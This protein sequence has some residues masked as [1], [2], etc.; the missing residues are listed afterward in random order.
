MNKMLHKSLFIGITALGLFA[1]AGVA[2]SQTVSAKSKAVKVTKN[3]ATKS[4]GADRNVI[5]TGNYAIYTKPGTVKGA[6]MF[7]SKGTLRGLA[8]S[9]NS[10]DYF[11]AY[12]VAKTNKGLWYAK[13]VS[14]DYKNRGWIYVGKTNPDDDWASVGFGLKHTE[15]THTAAMPGTTTVK[16]TNPGITNVLWNAPYRSQYR[17]EKTIDDTEPYGGENFTVTKSVEMT[18]E[19]TPYYYI[20]NQD[21]PSVRGWIYAG[22]VIEQVPVPTDPVPNNVVFAKIVDADS[23]YEVGTPTLTNT[24]TSLTNAAAFLTTELGNGS[25]DE[26]KLGAY[27]P[28]YTYS[29]LSAA[30]KNANYSA[31]ANAAYGSTVTVKAR[32]ASK[33]PADTL[34]DATLANATK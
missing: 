30:D 7:A 11:R 1:A 20:V 9:Q 31:I 4:A 33:A 13:V 32:L 28:G 8:G 18:R 23:G 29:T 2:G 27:A 21:R 10:K 3:Y 34:V 6:R 16:L 12:R 19:G 5:P 14:F 22:A 25:T 15:T 26:A 17:A 24:N